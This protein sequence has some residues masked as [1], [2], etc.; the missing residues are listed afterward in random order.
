MILFEMWNKENDNDNLTL[1]HWKKNSE[2]IA[3][4]SKEAQHLSS[5]NF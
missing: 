4:W 2:K 3:S 5:D 1:Y